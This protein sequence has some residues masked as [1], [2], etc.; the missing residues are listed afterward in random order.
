MITT[1]LLVLAA[2]VMAGTLGVIV[3]SLAEFGSVHLHHLEIDGFAAITAAVAI[4]SLILGGTP[5]L[6]GLLCGLMLALLFCLY[7]VVMLDRQRWGA[8]S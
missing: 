2:V 4:A 3:A 6:G 7:V 5:A 1:A 8:K